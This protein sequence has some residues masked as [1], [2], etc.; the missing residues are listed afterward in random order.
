MRT[1]INILQCSQGHLICENCFKNV[2]VSTKIYPFSKRDV[3]ATPVRNRAS[4][5][6]IEN[7]A[8]KDMGTASQN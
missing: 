6:I 4:E 5:E 3:V 7:E 1:P 8:R 2:S